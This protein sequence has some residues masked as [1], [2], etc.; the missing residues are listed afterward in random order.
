MRLRF[1][2][3]LQRVDARLKIFMS[4]LAGV[5]TWQAG[6][7]G[8][9]VFFLTAVLLGWIVA[10]HGLIGRRQVRGLVL[11]VGL[12]TGI[13][14][15]ME[16]LEHNPHWLED[17]LILGARLIILILVGISLA[18]L[19]SRVQV[20]QAVSSLLRPILG[21]KSW[22]GAMALALMIHFIPVSMRVMN[23]LKQTLALR[24]QGLSLWLR[25]RLYVTSVLR[26]L[27]R[28]TWDQTLALA[29]RGLE[30]DAAWTGKQSLSS[31]QWAGG[32]VL[33]GIMLTLALWL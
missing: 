21:H 13:K 31:A 19:T 1:V 5:C 6:P 23:T 3:C 27:S 17:S 22:H 25:L 9:S 26:N 14:A 8:L 30:E 32:A 20:G 18:A 2:H 10:G 4:I 12:W 29:V 7:L 15:A 33:G 11:F 28:T 24:A 16:L